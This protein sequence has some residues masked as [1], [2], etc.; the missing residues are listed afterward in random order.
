MPSLFHHV[1]AH[2]VLMLPFDGVVL[3]FAPV[4]VRVQG[5]AQQGRTGR[6]AEVGHRPSLV[7][8]SLPST[9]CVF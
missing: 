1:H 9:K 5:I 3:A 4:C 2:R 8:L 7:S 6:G